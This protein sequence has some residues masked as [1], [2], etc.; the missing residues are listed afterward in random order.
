[1]LSI[2]AHDVELGRVWYGMQET[3]KFNCIHNYVST[4]SILTIILLLLIFN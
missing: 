2:H 1:M 4:I 3:I